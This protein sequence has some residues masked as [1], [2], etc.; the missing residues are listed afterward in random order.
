MPGKFSELYRLFQK[1]RRGAE[2]QFG[3]YLGRQNYSSGIGPRRLGGVVTVY[4]PPTKLVQGDT[5]SVEIAG[6]NVTFLH[7]PGETVD[8][9]AVWLPDKRVLLPGD[10]IYRTFPNLYAIRGSPPRNPVQW[11]DSLQLMRKLGA[12]YLAPSHTI[13]VI[14]EQEIYDLFTVY[15]AGIMFVHDQTVRYTNEGLHPD[16]ISQRVLLPK[17]LSSHDYLQEFYGTVVWSSKL[18]YEQYVGWFSGNIVDMFPRT[19]TERAKS[20]VKLVSGSKLLNEAEKA[21][22]DNDPRLALELSSYV[23]TAQ[24]DNDKA[25]DVRLRSLRVLASQEKNPCA[26]N[27]YLTAAIDDHK[28]MN[29]N[30]DETWIFNFREMKEVLYYMKIRVKAELT[31]GVNTTVAFCFEDTNEAFLLQMLYSVLTIEQLQSCDVD[32]SLYETKMITTSVVWKDIVLKKRSVSS[33]YSMGLIKT[34]GSFASLLT[35]VSYFGIIV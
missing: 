14:G 10:D 19:P 7:I 30:F 8:Q 4:H 35:F 32:N 17:S 15:M 25:R 20:I 9:L 6:L 2:Y 21:L 22:K 1:Y 28:L 11:H 29:W 16:E 31:D 34:E 12:Q 3:F 33:A 13:P 24:P 18:V 23:F 5:M 27:A 26:R